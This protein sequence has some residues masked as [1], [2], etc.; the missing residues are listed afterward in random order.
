MPVADSLALENPQECEMD[1]Y[2]RRREV[3]TM[4][5]FITLEVKA[6]W[7]SV[8][9]SLGLESPISAFVVS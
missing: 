3:G 9:I 1:K 2:C 8:P 7:K 4:N 5:D 6:S